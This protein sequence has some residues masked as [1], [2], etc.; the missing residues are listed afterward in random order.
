MFSYPY[1][2]LVEI[3]NDPRVKKAILL[4]YKNDRTSLDIMLELAKIRKLLYSN[5]K[6]ITEITKGLIMNN[7]LETIKFIE[8]TYE[9]YKELFYPICT[10][11]IE[12]KL[13]DT[14]EIF[15]KSF[16]YNIPTEM[17]YNY[18]N[19]KD[20]K[21]KRKI[22]ETWYNRINNFEMSIQIEKINNLLEQLIK[23][24]QIGLLDKVMSFNNILDK[25]P[26]KFKFIS[27]VLN[28]FDN[29]CHESTYKNGQML[30]VLFK[31][32]KYDFMNLEQCRKI[33]Y[34]L[35]SIRYFLDYVEIKKQYK[36]EHKQSVYIR[37][38]NQNTQIEFNDRNEFLGEDDISDYDKSLFRKNKHNNDTIIN[39]ICFMISIH[40]KS[41]IQEIF[42]QRQPCK[43]ISCFVGEIEYPESDNDI[44]N[45][46]EMTNKV[47]YSQNKTLFEIIKISNVNL[48]SKL[49]EIDC[50]NHNINKWY[51]YILSSSSTEIFELY[52][53]KY[54]TEFFIEYSDYIFKNYERIVDFIFYFSEKFQNSFNIDPEY[55]DTI[56]NSIDK[57][58][59]Y[60]IVQ[61]HPK[62]QNNDF[63]YLHL[64]NLRKQN[65]I[66]EL[67]QNNTNLLDNK[68]Y[69]YL[70]TYIEYNEPSE[71]IIKYIFQ[72]YNLPWAY[73][74]MYKIIL[75]SVNYCKDN[76]IHLIYT[77]FSNICDINQI[78]S[79]LL[80]HNDFNDVDIIYTYFSKNYNMYIKSNDDALF[81]GIVSNGAWTNRN[82]EKSIKIFY[83]FCSKVEKNYYQL[84]LTNDKKLISYKCGNKLYG[85]HKYTIM[86][87]FLNISSNIESCECPICMECKTNIITNCNHHFCYQCLINHVSK[88]LND[89]YNIKVLMTNKCPLCR[90]NLFPIKKYYSNIFHT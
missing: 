71:T 73:P 39:Y 42:Y 17:Y 37:E 75:N 34:R 3:K 63:Y 49:L 68:Y 88:N 66:M 16:N 47:R 18:D 90:Q 79:H 69:D 36:C 23:N 25:I 57:T 2:P 64:L 82:F 6:I 15:F 32:L 72:K 45:I 22:I 43:F 4:A 55:Y 59:F 5:S 53:Q 70:L 30:I 44:D 54:P 86:N 14:L 74:N 76:I 7:N 81:K 9:R 87:N 41:L 65:S 40:N 27:M 46:N 19:K 77:F 38:S 80:N 84:T 21:N 24:E 52:Y 51:K 35:L 62:L 8:N 83:W 12:L 61:I 48:F 1:V 58:I 29:C 26:D 50:Y 11:C 31:S 60:K 85:N 67:L 13:F 33:L 20:K 10:Q 56:I 78:I 89:N 28:K